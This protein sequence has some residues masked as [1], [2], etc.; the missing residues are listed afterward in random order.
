KISV[1]GIHGRQVRIGIDAP[2]TVVVHREEIYLKIQSENRKASKTIKEDLIGMM[3]LIKDKIQGRDASTP[4]ATIN[5]KDKNA[6]PRGNR[7]NGQDRTTG[8]RR[9]E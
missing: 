5:Y 8:S 7:P 4:D 3:S 2:P 9:E 6:K 1:L